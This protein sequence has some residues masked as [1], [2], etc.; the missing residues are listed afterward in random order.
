MGTT[1]Q[2]VHE[3]N[4]K[5]VGLLGSG[6]VGDVSVERDTLLSGTSLGDGQ[7]DTQDGV[8]AEV[9]LVG[10]AIQ[11]DEELVDLGLVLDVDVLLDEGRS[12]DLVDVLDGLQD[13]CSDTGQ[14]S[15][16]FP[17]TRGVLI[18]PFPSHLD[19]SP[20]RSSQASC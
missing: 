5:D 2:D 8:G 19:L 7:G 4:R 10:G 20:S 17:V 6:E 14:P 1:V 11:L 12:N 15:A 9:G 13:T 16:P 18:S 3:G